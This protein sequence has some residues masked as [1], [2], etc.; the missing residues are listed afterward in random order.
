M[1]GV[2]SQRNLAAH[3]AK[4]LVG[5]PKVYPAFGAELAGAWRAKARRAESGEHEWVE[6]EFEHMAMVSGIEVYETFAPGSVVRVCFRKWETG[7]WDTVWQGPPQH[8]T[9]QQGAPRVFA[10]LLR[11]RTYATNAVRLQLSPHGKQGCGAVDAVR[12][13]GA[14]H[15]NMAPPAAGM[16]R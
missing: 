3:A 4:Q 6:L 10:P 8:A 16:A 14:P 2:S 9:V 15:A 11:P 12:L 7:E 1:C 13:L 5:P